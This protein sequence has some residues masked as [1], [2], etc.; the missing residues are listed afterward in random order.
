MMKPIYTEIDVFEDTVEGYAYFF[1]LQVDFSV[2]M[3]DGF[4]DWVEFK[5]VRVDPESGEPE[6][7]TGP[8]GILM[9][10]Q[11]EREAIR[12]AIETLAE[13]VWHYDGSL[14]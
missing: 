4:A 13:D 7:A 2:T 6:T 1:G 5:A 9:I 14:L 10:G 8:H 3:R 11:D 12:D